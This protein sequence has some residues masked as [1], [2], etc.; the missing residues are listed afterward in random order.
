MDIGKIREECTNTDDGLHEQ[1]MQANPYD[2]FSA[3]FQQAKSGGEPLANAMQLATADKD[4][5]PGIRTVLLKAVDENGFIFYTNYTS[6]KARDIEANSQVALHF[7]WHDLKRQVIIKGLARKISQQAS[8][9][10]FLSRPYESQL[11][12]WSSRQSQITESRETLDNNFKKMKHRFKEGSV[13]LP[14]FWGGY[15]V[16]PLS[17]EFWQ[18]NLNRLHD[19]FRYFLRS[20]NKTAGSSSDERWVMKRLCP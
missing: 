14:P 12:A 1:E 15:Q 18:E 6:D 7:F 10:Y 16:E 19:R 11:G 20:E 3:W 9:A 2:Q 5:I 4:G 17:I 13:P 8:L